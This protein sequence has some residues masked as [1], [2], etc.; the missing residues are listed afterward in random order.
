MWYLYKAC[1]HKWATFQEENQK[2]PKKVTR[3]VV[4][5]KY[6]KLPSIAL[7]HVYARGL[8]GGREEHEGRALVGMFVVLKNCVAFLP[9]Y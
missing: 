4:M 2:L 6:S 8:C 7:L 5:G 3:G 9:C 1:A